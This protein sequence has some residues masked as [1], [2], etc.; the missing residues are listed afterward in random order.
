[1]QRRKQ[2]FL[3]KIRLGWMFL[4]A[5]IIVAAFGIFIGREFAYLPYNFGIITALGL[6]MM[7]IGV[8]FLVR[9]RAVMKDEE[10]ARRLI[11]EERDERTVLI[12]AR[13][14]NRAYWVSTGLVYAGLMWASFAANGSLPSLSGD[15]LWYF[16]AFALLI[17]FGVYAG[18]IL[19]DQRNT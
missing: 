17:P 7:G 8:N 5:G 10:S 15:T 13:A 16:L 4:V 19:V 2:F 14:G 11:A 3:A 1:M 12:R 18:S 6:L 9:Y